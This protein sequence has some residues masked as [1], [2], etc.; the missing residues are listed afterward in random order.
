[1]KEGWQGLLARCH[2]RLTTWSH[3]LLVQNIDDM[4]LPGFQPAGVNDK[5]FNQISRK[6]N[7]KLCLISVDSGAAI[8]YEGIG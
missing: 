2:C 6:I 7:E 8:S 3:Y 5:I 4:P 1:M